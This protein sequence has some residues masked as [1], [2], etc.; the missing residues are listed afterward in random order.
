MCKTVITKAYLG[1]MRGNLSAHGKDLHLEIKVLEGLI[2]LYFEI[3]IEIKFVEI[4]HFLFLNPNQCF[5]RC[6]CVKLKYH[7]LS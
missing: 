6:M 3:F 4:I 5:L 2:N 7:L 1:S